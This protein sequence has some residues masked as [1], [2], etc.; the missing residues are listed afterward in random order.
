MEVSKLVIFPHG[1]VEVT[2]G[3]WVNKYMIGGTILSDKELNLP[4]EAI[5]MG[6]TKIMENLATKV[7]VAEYPLG[8]LGTA[9]IQISSMNPDDLEEFKNDLDEE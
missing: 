3:R 8:E 7:Y 9:V 5:I 2:P 4:K 6:E 1:K